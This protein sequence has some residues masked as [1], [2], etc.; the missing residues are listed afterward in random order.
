MKWFAMTSLFALSSLVGCGAQ[1][2]AVDPSNEGTS[3]QELIVGNWSGPSAFL[4]SGAVTT[5]QPS[6]NLPVCRAPFDNGWHP[7]KFW[8]GQCL[9]EWG[10]QGLAAGPDVPERKAQVANFETLVN[11]GGISWVPMVKVDCSSGACWQFL[12]PVP[13]NAID[14]G[15]AG[16]QAGNAP[17]PVC[18]ASWGGQYHPGKWW[19]SGCNIE[20]GGQGL[21]LTGDK[22]PG[23]YIATKN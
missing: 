3:P 16:S 17:L 6:L 15:P 5:G 8:K 10:G 23:L 4:A 19:A 11:N 7:G 13:Q 1:T 12:Q 20:Y 9:F 2:D 18:M 14:G 21:H 22:T